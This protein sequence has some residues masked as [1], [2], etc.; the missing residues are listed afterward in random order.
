MKRIFTIFLTIILCL[1]ALFSLTACND[2][3]VSGD[4]VVNPK[5]KTVKV[6]Y[7]E[8]YGPLNYTYRNKLDGFNTRLAILVFNALGY[9]V[10]FVPIEVESA[11]D[12]YTALN[13]TIDCFWGGLSDGYLFDSSKADFSYRYMEN[14][15]CIVANTLNTDFIENFED[16]SGKS[17]CYSANSVANNYIKQNLSRFN[18][19]EV[20]LVEH[21][22]SQDYSIFEVNKFIS[23][24]ANFA[25]VDTLFALYS[26]K[27]EYTSCTINLDELDKTAYKFDQSYY[28]RVVFPKKTED[29]DPTKKNKLRDDVNVMLKALFDTGVLKALA[30]SYTYTVSSETIK[31]TDYLYT[32]D[33]N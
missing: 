22:K 12:V 32:A 21:E 23:Q 15:L 19:N 2:K 8:E 24:G 10:T 33:F 25:I 11:D 29:G 9:E 14:S 26:I 17:V 18:E 4:N 13:G 1:S 3:S 20:R 6:G 16:L 30:D 31:L 7:L 5:E 28:L 27:N